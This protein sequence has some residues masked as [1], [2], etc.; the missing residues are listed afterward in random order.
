MAAVRPASPSGVLVVDKPSG[1]TSHDVVARVRRALRTREVGHAGT[2]D[3]M[4]TGVLVVAIGEATKLVPYLTADDKAYVAEITFGRATDTLDA[5]GTTTREGE[6][7][8]DLE[9]RLVEALALEEARTEQVPP[10]FSAIHV[11]GE[12]AHV[13]ARRGEVVDLPARA[14]AARAL[15]LEALTGHTARV[16]VEVA[17]GYYVRALARDLGD[18]VGCPAHLSSLRRTRSGAFRVED[19][20]RLDGDLGAALVPLTDAAARAL[21]V[22]TLTPNGVADA[23]AGRPIASVNL[24]GAPPAE[25]AAFVADGV[26]VAIGQVEGDGRGRVIRGFRPPPTT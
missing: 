12:R 20:A 5:E 25:H 4:A 18:R 16:R 23:R 21:P 17:K 10:A 26:L 15:R 7:P 13:L 11:A 19:A 24:A 14:V 8:T 2:L 9:A 3:P 1:M 22:F 6:V